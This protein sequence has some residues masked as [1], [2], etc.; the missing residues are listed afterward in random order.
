MLEVS[1][2]VHPVVHSSWSPLVVS[3][4]LPGLACGRPCGSVDMDCVVCVRGDWT[5]VLSSATPFVASG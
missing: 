3:P 1:P 4:P 2:V 5:R